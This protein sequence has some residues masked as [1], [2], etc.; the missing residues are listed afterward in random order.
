MRYEEVAEKFHV[1]PEVEKE[2][3]DNVARALRKQE[4]S[5]KAIRLLGFQRE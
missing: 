1:S 3:V 2:V 5:Q 4:P